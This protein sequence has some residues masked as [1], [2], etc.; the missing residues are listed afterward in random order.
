[1]KRSYYLI[2]FKRGDKIKTITDAFTH[3]LIFL[4]IEKELQYKTV[5]LFYKELTKEEY[6]YS[7]G[8]FHI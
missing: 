1:M 5:I 7:V 4:K 8:N 6:E 2:T 3:P